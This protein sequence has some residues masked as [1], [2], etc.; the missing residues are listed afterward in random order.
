MRI[1][2]RVATLPGAACLPVVLVHGLG[3][4]SRYFVPTALSLAPSYHVYAPDLPGFGRSD[5]PPWVLD[6]PE[7]ADILAAWMETVGLERAALIGNSMGCQTVANLAIRHPERI[8]RAVLV[9]PSMDRRG[10]NG[11]EQFRRALADLPREPA[12]QWL[13]V[14]RDYLAAGPLRVARTLR[15]AL[16]DRIEDQLPRVRVPV[17]V[18][19]GARDPIAPQRW[20][21][22]VTRLLPRGRLVVIPGAAHTVNYSAPEALTAVVRP[23]LDEAGE[24]P[25]AAGAPPAERRIQSRAGPHP[26]GD[27]DRVA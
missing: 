1:H 5:K 24:P 15:H 9:G 27:L 3:V 4:S 13:T 8:E 2:A 10:R 14:A 25:S 17:L 11:L 7:L 12:S 18:V 20:A 16:R 21:E 26:T 19:R 23:F 6:L 22:E